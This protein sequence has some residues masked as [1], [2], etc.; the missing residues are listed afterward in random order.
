MNENPDEILRAYIEK[1]LALKRERESQ[2]L[3]DDDLKQIA[4]EAGMTDEDLAYAARRMGEHMSRGESF[5]R[6]RNWSG[7][8]SELEEAEA[9]A[10]SNATVLAVLANAYLNRLREGG[11]G[12]DR[13]NAR[14]AAE[15]CLRI[16][17]TNDMA[18]R[19]L[20]TLATP[21]K[22]AVATAPTARRSVIRIA[23]LASVI[24]LAGGFVFM[25]IPQ[26]RSVRVTPPQ[27]G[28]TPVQPTPPAQPAAPAPPEKPP[29]EA[30]GIAKLAMAFGDEGIGPGMFKDARAIAVAPDG[31]IYVGEYSDGRIQSFG[32][33]GKFITQFTIGAHTY[34]K[35]LAADRKGRLYAA[36]NGAIT[37]YDADGTSR[38]ELPYSGGR[39]FVDVAATAD[40]GLI[41]A[42]DGHYRGGILINVKSKD[43][44]VRFNAAGR[45]VKTMPQ[46]ISKVTDNVEMNTEVIEDGA[47][48]IY[49]LASYGA[50]L[51]K[52]KPDGSLADR[53]AGATESGG[54]NRFRS[55]RA[56]AVD[57]KGRVFVGTFSGIAVL[58]GEGHELGT[59]PV[60]GSVDDIAV[61]DAGAVYVLLRHR[62]EKYVL[63]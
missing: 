12:S 5:L 50:A 42:W 43:A 3:N 49:A 45:A 18:L 13:E 15:R 54:D 57:G 7:A 44:I 17:P 30:A 48:Y 41:A 6:Y 24:A 22:S 47:G 40:G 9:L 46:A 2:A 33:D 51:L 58:D 55:A 37:R 35:G 39:G 60:K 20:S 28:A 1:I 36:S 52:F 10:P 8:I 27:P 25:L 4:L 31:T 34:L 63:R 32:P 23:L 11:E 16:D 59:I 53:I 61:D 56:L 62:V 21:A 26:S 19:V 29:A 38:G 14:A